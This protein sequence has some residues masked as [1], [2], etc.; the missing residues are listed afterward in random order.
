M[1]CSHVNMMPNKVTKQKLH[2]VLCF[3]TSVTVSSSVLTLLIHSAQMQW[4]RF[5]GATHENKV[6]RVTQN[7]LLV[8]CFDVVLFTFAAVREK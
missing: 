7:I 3:L 8:V 5:S 1:C 2:R 4:K 6:L